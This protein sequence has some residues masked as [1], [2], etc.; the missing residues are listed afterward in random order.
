MP[1]LFNKVLCHIQ[2]ISSRTRLIPKK[3]W[4]KLLKWDISLLDMQFLALSV[5][6]VSAFH[7]E[8]TVFD[9]INTVKTV[10]QFYIDCSGDTSASPFEVEVNSV[11]SFRR[12]LLPHINCIA[13]FR[14]RLRIIIISRSKADLQKWA[15]LCFGNGYA[16]TRPLMLPKPCP[17]CTKFVIIILGKLCLK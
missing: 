12:F 7:I 16:S 15:A 10:L 6:D 4:G 11:P 8:Y 1:F 9:H 17:L 2:R 5:N 14:L 13:P 3:V